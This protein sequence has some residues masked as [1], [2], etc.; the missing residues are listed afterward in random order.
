LTVALTAAALP[1]KHG[2]VLVIEDLSELISAQR[3]SAWREVARR[4]A[5]EIKNPLTPIQLSAERIAKRALSEPEAVA[6]GLRA[7]G[8][9]VQPSYSSDLT[10]N[11]IR[12]GTDTI[13]REVQ[14]LKAMVDE[15]SQFARLPNVE[16]EMGSVNDVVEQAAGL[17]LDRTDE[18]RLET[19]ID[20]DVPQTK[21][22]T[23]QLKRALVNLIDN[24]I[25][26]PKGSEPKAVVVSSRH[27]TARDQI[28]IE[29][30]DNGKG[31]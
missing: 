29:V 4:M 8:F 30:A 2:V 6:T 28:I 22:D 10:A 5:H 3:A 19:H 26:A 14:S 18:L 24:A 17:Y 23:E 7:A 9:D 25:E 1:D 15:F 21:I 20:P 27:D 31:D 13:I 11:V 16:L 12:D